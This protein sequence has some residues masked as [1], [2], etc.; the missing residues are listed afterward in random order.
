MS[1]SLLGALG[2][3][4]V[5]QCPNCQEFINTSMAQCSYCGVSVNYESA[6]A[7]AGVQRQVGQACSD[8]SYLKIM[9][10]AQ[11]VFYALSWIPFVGGFAVWGW[12]F[13]VFAI[14]IMLIRWWVKFRAL[15]TADPDFE[16]ARRTTIVALVIW[17]VMMIIWFVVGVINALITRNSGGI[18]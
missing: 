3:P 17:S 8:A 16:N 5:F 11:I 13:L 6:Q 12:L 4:E 14:P 7:A 9:A 18:A 2:Q 1:Q 15:Q 10:R